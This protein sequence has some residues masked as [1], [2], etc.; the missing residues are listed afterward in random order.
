MISKLT[1][2]K[3]VLEAVQEN[4]L[5]RPEQLVSFDIEFGLPHCIVK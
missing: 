3:S 2:T 1:S 5:P 4:Y